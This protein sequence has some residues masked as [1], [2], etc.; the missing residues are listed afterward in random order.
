L[1]IGKFTLL[2]RQLKLPS[3]LLALAAVGLGSC[4]GDKTASLAP[5][6]PFVGGVVADEPR[7][8]LVGR[9]ILQAG[10]SAADAVAAAYFAMAVTLPA[11]ASL[12][13]G[14]VCVI[15]DPKL[16]R[17][18]AID[19]VARAP[20]G[21]G[22]AAVPANVR[23]IYALQA[24]Y[25]KL[26]WEQVVAPAEG[27]AR[28][29]TTVSRAMANDL[30]AA[31][32]AIGADDAARRIFL[33]ADGT[34]Y[35][36][37]DTIVQR[38]LSGVLAAIRARGPGEVH[39][40]PAAQTFAAGAA[41]INV[42]ITV[43][44][45]RA[46]LPAWR[47]TMT[48]RY[49]D[50]TLNFAAPPAIAGVTEA[51]M[52]SMLA[53]RWS[54]LSPDERNHALA[55]ASLYAA[56]DRTGWLA[57]DMTSRVPVPELIG[58]RRLDALMSKYKSDNRTVP[59]SLQPPPSAEEAETP[60]AGI[61]AADATGQ[62]VA[63]TVS[64]NAA[65]GLGRVVAGTGIVLAAVPDGFKN[66]PQTMGPV[67]AARRAEGQFL[68]AAAGGGG[69]AVPEAVIK[70]ALQTIIERRTLEQAIEAPRLHYAAARD[71][72][73]LE[74]SV[75]PTPSGLEQRGYTVTAAT[76]PIGRVNA[77]FCP[78]G[79]VENPNSCQ[80]RADRRGFGLAAGPD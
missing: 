78:A 52:W 55:Q 76:A 23:G 58:A 3:I 51:Q 49:D 39:G 67:V 59:A 73:V 75:P 43:D 16:S 19:F 8:A 66:G 57:S 18:E 80:F 30:A 56:S 27:L 33:K 41:A 74:P 32:A 69:A 36:E 54:R 14:G 38:D 72:V 44:D 25:G 53:P 10:G 68:F 31:A 47:P 5:L 79:L 37:G 45:L 15:Y 48:V 60:V 26:R 46:V 35:R 34:P 4:G 11:V 62:A 50:I 12:G 21:G 64:T 29:G 20:A 1:V 28:F 61:V 63:C 2:R 7:A 6:R 77:I 65:F 70:V 13:G 71:T 9:D 22:P 24:K 40:G 17:S 42:P